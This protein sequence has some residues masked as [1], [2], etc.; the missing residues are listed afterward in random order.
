VACR[1]T[2]VSLVGALRCIGQLLWALPGAR[3][4]LEDSQTAL[5]ISVR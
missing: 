2:K 3:I 5:L 4:E 1:V